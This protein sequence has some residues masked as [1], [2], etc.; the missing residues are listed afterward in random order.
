MYINSWRSSMDH[1]KSILWDDYRGVI[2]KDSGSIADMI[3]R[4]E[5][6]KKE[7]IMAAFSR[8]ELKTAYLLAQ[9]EAHE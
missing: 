1:V 3:R 5:G 6:V 9:E 7:E 8:M 2:L 4:F